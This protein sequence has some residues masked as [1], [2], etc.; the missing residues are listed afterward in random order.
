AIRKY[1]LTEKNADFIDFNLL[2]DSLKINKNDFKDPNHLN[3][4]GGIKHTEF[5][6]DYIKKNYVINTPKY[7]INEYNRYESIAS[8]FENSLSSIKINEKDR[9][10]TGISRLHLLKNNKDRFE[11]LFQF[12]SKSKPNK[13]I[14]IKMGAM[15]NGKMEWNY[16]LLK[17]A[18]HIEYRGVKYAVYQFNQK[19][20]N[21]KNSKL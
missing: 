19:T 14:H 21:L 15:V 16:A 12:V 11:L 7:R 2:V 3:V 9:K 1:L 10:L 5:L 8:G 6:A 20:E 18:D 17:R 13:N 4:M